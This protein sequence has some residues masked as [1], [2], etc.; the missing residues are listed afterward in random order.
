MEILDD[1]GLRTPQTPFPRKSLIVLVAAF[2]F[3]GLPLLVMATM[4]PSEW[5]DFCGVSMPTSTNII[6]ASIG[7]GGVL[8]LIF[9]IILG[10]WQWQRVRNGK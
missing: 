2:L 1:P 5:S 8:F 4:S 9:V 10:R 3:A 6:Y 7:L